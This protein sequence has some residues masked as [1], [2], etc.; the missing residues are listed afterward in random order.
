[1]SD[2]K[3]LKMYLDIIGGTVYYSADDIISINHGG[4]VDIYDGY[5]EMIYY[6]KLE[7]K[8]AGVKI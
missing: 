2:T 8:K 1:M 6:I 3:L 7:L 5:L 4:T